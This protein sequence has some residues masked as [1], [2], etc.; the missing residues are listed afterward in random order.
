M[1]THPASEPA[2]R[3]K[4]PA[5]RSHK[6]SRTGCEQ[7]KVRRVKCDETRPE[8]SNCTYRD[9]HCTYAKI[10]KDPAPDSPAAPAVPDDSLHQGFPDKKQPQG[11][12]AHDRNELPERSIEATEQKYSIRDLELM[13]RF[14][15]DTYKYL[16][17][18][19]TDMQEWQTHI[20]QYAY[21]YEF[22]M[23][24]ILALAALHTTAI[25]A[26]PD[27]ALPYLDSALHYNHLSFGPFRHALS[28]LTP[29]NCDAVYAYSA[30]I[31]A[32]NIALPL[33]N[34]RLRGEHL[35]MIENMVTAFELVQGAGNISRISASWLQASIFSKSSVWEMQNA[36]L[37]P[38]TVGA[39]E[40]LDRLN[41]SVTTADPEELSTNHET[42][43][44]LRSF[45]S[46][47]AHSPHPAPILAWL[48]YVKKDFVD[49]LRMRRPFQLLVLMH[50]GV[51]LH[52]LGHHFWWAEGSG[53][54]LVAELLSVLEVE[55]PEW[56]RALE[57][58]QYKVGC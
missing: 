52:E 8:C 13:H 57:W 12:E 32:L 10:A 15:V 3:R 43:E 31:T 34:A 38:Q 25:T 55:V 17:G 47:F 20:P 9:L 29:Q 33:L 54:A 56:E 28:H 50:W 37:D 23:H 51:L 30:I 16:C 58:P 21:K 5:R 40:Q 39:L 45:F 48:F 36:E 18:D 2:G 11:P 24:G 27:K 49:R 35:T 42:I 41:H 1:E 19:Q 44:I 22:L 6:K 7:C 26:D 4:A 53:K 46:K 14:S